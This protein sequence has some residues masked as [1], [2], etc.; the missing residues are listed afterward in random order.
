MDVVVDR[1]RARTNEA[2]TLKVTLSGEGNIRVLSAPPIRFPDGFEVY[3]PKVSE[4]VERANDTIRGYKT[5]EY[6][7]IP[8]RAGRFTIRNLRFSYFDP[9]T[10]KYVTKRHPDIELRIERGK[11]LPSFS[12]SGLSKED[13][14]LLS[15]DI[16]YIAKT[17]DRFVDLRRKVYHRPGFWILLVAP[18]L[19]VFSGMYYRSYRERLA[20]NVAYARSRRAQKLAQKQLREARR[21]MAAGDVSRF[22]AETAR[23]ITSFVG[24][25]MNLEAAGLTSE[26]LAAALRKRGVEEPLVE[27][28]EKLLADCDFHRFARP[29]AP[30]EAMKKAYDV[31]RALLTRLEKAL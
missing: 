2:V 3:D 6:V 9:V 20:S 25:K 24:D 21:A 19:F 17:A 13:V 16:R 18:L 8:R 15:Q 27:A 12:R 26:E 10:A 29:E 14:R 23:A 7:L 31:A 1:R 4:K 30:E 11:E 28:F 5:F 22:Y